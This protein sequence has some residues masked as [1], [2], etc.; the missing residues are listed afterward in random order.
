ML[1]LLLEPGHPFSPRHPGTTCIRHLRRS[2][3]RVTLELLAHALATLLPESSRYDLLHVWWF[4]I[5]SLLRFLVALAPA[6]N[7]WLAGSRHRVDVEMEWYNLAHDSNSARR[8]E[9]DERQERVE[10]ERAEWER[11]KVGNRC[12][13]GAA[14]SPGSYHLHPHSQKPHSFVGAYSHQQ[15]GSH[16]Q[17]GRMREQRLAPT[18][19]VPHVY[20][21]AESASYLSSSSNS[22]SMGASSV[23]PH[24]GS[25][26]YLPLQGH[27][28]PRSTGA[29][30]EMVPLE[31]FG[32]LSLSASTSTPST[33]SIACSPPR[34]RDVKCAR[35]V[36]YTGP[37]LSSALSFM[38]YTHTHTAHS[39]QVRTL[40]P[41]I[42]L[43]TELPK[44]EVHT[45]PLLDTTLK[46]SLA[47]C[48]AYH[49]QY[50]QSPLQLEHA[51]NLIVKS[52]LFA[53]HLE[54][55]CE[56]LADESCTN[57]DRHL[58]LIMYHI[59][60]CHGQCRSD[61]LRYHKPWVP[62]LPLLM[63]HAL[64]EINSDFFIPIEAKL[65]SLHDLTPERRR[66]QQQQLQ[67]YGVAYTP[68]QS[69]SSVGV[70]G[71]GSGSGSGSGFLYVPPPLSTVMQYLSQYVFGHHLLLR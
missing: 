61:F 36:S 3:V 5:H 6:L 54:Q 17:Q 34:E 14:F 33:N 12:R 4:D 27:G 29:G 2:R 68:G 8:A 46:R 21:S 50:L 31:R 18:L 49:E 62:L 26:S 37:S 32:T 13:T 47:L 16:Q 67:V 55:M 65:C 60:L 48:A 42:C 19:L 53:F 59:L 25:S 69:A 63:D 39:G 64:V 70:F 10:R 71:S 40:S 56:I 66:A 58:Q 22:N 28:Y 38:L 1:E 15:P 41:P 7:T 43:L 9:L 57:T 44:D 11:S 24:G 52:E 35:P 30:T 51:C 23:H 45:L 20:S